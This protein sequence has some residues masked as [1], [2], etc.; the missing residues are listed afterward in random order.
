MRKVINRGFT[1]IELLVVI[2]IIGILASIILVSV[3]GAR[4]KGRDAQRVSNLQQAAQV[5]ASDSVNSDTT[6]PINGCA[7]GHAA[8]TACSGPGNAAQLA[9]IVDPGGNTT[10]CAAAPTA[11][12]EYSISTTAGA[13]TPLFNNWQITTYIE[14]A[15]DV[16]G[17]TGSAGTVACIS[18]ATTSIMLGT[19]LCH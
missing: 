13:A 5:L 10:A 3:N 12:C 16:V 14:T 6:N 9:G 8:L 19:T 17:G 4:S 2:A 15:S 1:L 18:S 7:A 11:P